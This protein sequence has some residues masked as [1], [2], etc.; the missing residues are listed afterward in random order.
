MNLEVHQI[1]A[2]DLEKEHKELF[3]QVEQRTAA[4]NQLEAYKSLCGDK[5]QILL[6]QT[7]VQCHI[8]CRL[9]CFEKSS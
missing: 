9:T 3:I 8:F 2:L 4:L 7:L 1:C 6:A 5:L